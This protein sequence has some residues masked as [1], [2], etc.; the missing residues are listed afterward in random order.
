VKKKQNL[1]SYHLPFICIAILILI[2]CSPVVSATIITESYNK[3]YSTASGLNYDPSGSH[4]LANAYIH[5]SNISSISGATNFKVSAVTIS[6]ANASNLMNRGTIIIP[7]ALA[8]L[9]DGYSQTRSP[10]VLTLT[11]LSNTTGYDIFGNPIKHPTGLI[12]SMQLRLD[13]PLE[14]VAGDDTDFRIYYTT[15]NSYHFF[16]FDEYMP[17]ATAGATALPAAA[18][19]IFAGYFLTEPSMFLGTGGPP[20]DFFGYDYSQYSTNYEYQF[21]NIITVNNVAM[22]Y[23]INKVITGK[24]TLSQAN[25]TDGNGNLYYTPLGDTTI[26]NTF[27]ETPIKIW[28]KEARYGTVFNRTYF[29]PEYLYDVTPSTINSLTEFVTGTLSLS[30]S[31][32][33]NVKFYKISD[34]TTGTQHPNFYNESSPEYYS[35]SFLKIG[36]QW[37]AYNASTGYSSNMSP[38]YG[39]GVMPNGIELYFK[40]GGTRNLKITVQ[41]NTDAFY[42][43]YATVTVSNVGKFERAWYPT[44]Y[45]TGDFISGSTVRVYDR[46]TLTAEN[47]TVY[48]LADCWFLLSEGYYNI[49]GFAPGYEHQDNGLE[50]VN[51]GGVAEQI[52]LYPSDTNPTG[53]LTI[54]NVFINVQ[55]DVAGQTTRAP[56]YQATVQILPVGLI[57]QTSLSGTAPFYNLTNGTAYQVRVTKT[58]YSSVAEYF[59]PTTFNYYLTIVIEEGTGAITL[60]PTTGPTVPTGVIP[61]GTTS[62]ILTGNYTGFW[63]PVGNWFGAMGA[64][65]SEMG[66]LLTCILIFIG[67][68]VGGWSAAPY[69]AGAPF[70]APASM[71][72]AVIGFVA[73]C[74]FGF[75]PLVWVVS[76]VVIGVFWFMF[77]GRG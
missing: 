41:D 39:Y 72:G 61:T 38:I 50:Y 23:K 74:A 2:L 44:D 45:V 6:S 35:Q 43:V 14:Y 58:G 27:I 62:P 68:A 70:N 63:G 29:A 3:T 11:P 36:P 77:F 9:G 37:W 69:Q 54:S 28:L 66:I 22:T 49:E 60:T 5:F 56:V 13:D 75:I 53:N 19:S 7:V 71:G 51:V 4:L 20:G 57:Q 73:A 55:R 52:M 47:R 21:E 48:S 15:K 65:P 34:I 1:F 33:T 32:P 18:T 64:A 10:G 24:T 17:G 42:Y 8:G 31:V 46:Q 67:F 26:E 12:M 76:I 40:E 16:D 30:G 25:I 59:T